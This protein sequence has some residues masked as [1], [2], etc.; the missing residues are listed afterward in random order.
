M[1]TTAIPI[2][3]V[4]DVISKNRMPT[5]VPTT[6]I[7]IKAKRTFCNR[8]NDG[9]SSPSSSSSKRAVRFFSMEPQSKEVFLKGIFNYPH[10][11]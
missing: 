3:R 5:I 2:I 9:V 6:P 8:E 4:Y 11:E 1:S 7:Q 10:E